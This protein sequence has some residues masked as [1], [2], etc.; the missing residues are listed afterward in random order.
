M[1]VDASAKWPGLALFGSALIWL[2]LGGTLQLIAAIQLHTPTFLVDCA[3]F[4]YGR[5]APAAQNALFMSA[6]T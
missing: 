5:I 4:T 3:W 6:S 2:L 1:Q